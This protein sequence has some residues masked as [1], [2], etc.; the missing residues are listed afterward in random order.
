MSATLK[1]LYL[2]DIPVTRV[3]SWAE[4]A[5][6]LNAEFATDWHGAEL[7]TM[8]NEMPARGDDA[9]GFWLPSKAAIG[10]SSDI[11]A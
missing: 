4:A 10:R 1:P 3:A 7:S 9:G 2:N 6:W 11:A 5:E 8:G